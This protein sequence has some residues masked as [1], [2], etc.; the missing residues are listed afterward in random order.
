MREH[1]HAGLG[2]GSGPRGRLSRC[3]SSSSSHQ[4][5]EFRPTWTR[6]G[7]R[8]CPSSRLKCCREYVTP[9][10]SNK[11]RYRTSRR[12]PRAGLCSSDNQSVLLGDVQGVE[13]SCERRMFQVT[14]GLIFT[15]PPGLLKLYGSNITVRTLLDC[16]RAKYHLWPWPRSEITS[17]SLRPMIRSISRDQASRAARFSSA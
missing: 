1:H 13:P 4:A 2:G 7:Q 15:K 3:S 17:A 9:K 10:R 16:I 5:I 12:A 8:P 14:E 6:C 11:S